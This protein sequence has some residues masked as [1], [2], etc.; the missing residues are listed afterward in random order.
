VKNFGKPILV[1]VAICVIIAG[2]LA[3][4][5]GVTEPVITEN[6][7]F[8]AEAA[9]KELLPAASSFVEI[10]SDDGAVVYLAD[11][12]D[13]IIPVSA[14]GYGGRASLQILIAISRG[15]TIIATKTLSNG[16]TKGLGSRVSDAAYESQFAGMDSSLGGYEGVT[17]ATISSTAYSGAVKKAFGVF[18]ALKAGGTV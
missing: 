12:G 5:R 10:S 11:T 8:R 7:A 14:N 13:V 2:A 4:V 17:G 9:R 3:A 6:A 15:G 16:E 18:A 1:L